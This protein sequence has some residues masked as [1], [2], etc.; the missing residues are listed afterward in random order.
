MSKSIHFFGKLVYSQLIKNID[1]AQILQIRS[2]HSGQRYVIS[3]DGWDHLITMFYAI[4]MRF[5]SL[6]EIE[7]S[8]LAKVRILAHLGMEYLLR[9][10]TLADANK[11]RS[12]KFF[13][14]VY[15]DLYNI[16]Q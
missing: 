2:K 4:I 13:E 16:C 12:E 15:R 10:S 5:D 3:F 1:K 6:C 11:S 8:M 14:D 7:A 9:R